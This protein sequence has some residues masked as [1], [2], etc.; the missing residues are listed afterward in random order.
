MA[1]PAPIARR[2]RLTVEDHRLLMLQRNGRLCLLSSHQAVKER[3][4]V[5]LASVPVVAVVA[6]ATPLA[7]PMRPR[8]PW[9]KPA[10]AVKCRA[11]E[12]TR[13]ETLG[14]SRDACTLCRGSGLH[15]GRRGV[16]SP[17]GCVLR[18]IFRICFN[19]F[20][21]L[22]NRDRYMS[23]VRMKQVGEKLR[24]VGST[25]SDGNRTGHF[26]VFV[27][28]RPDEE[29]IADFTLVS[30]RALDS[31]ERKVFR[32][33][34][35]LGFDWKICARRIGIDR[36]DFYHAVY[37]VEQKLGR[38]FREL[39]PYALFPLDEYFRGASRTARP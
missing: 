27:G 9:K 33:H 24:G 19:K 14:L 6:R 26:T 5:A 8:S 21:N 25:A 16:M 31:L 37:R 30:Y 15:L 22:S 1:C 29:Y 39:K 11:F 23:Q 20:V 7:P 10:A 13:S 18:A 4:A 2:R 36:G 35:L 12:W 32:L 34:F 38:A 17:C 3:P 28:G